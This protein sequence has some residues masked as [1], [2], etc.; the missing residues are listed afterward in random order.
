M[1]KFNNGDKVVP[2]QKTVKGYRDLNGSGAWKRAQILEQEYLFVVDWDEE[3]NCYILHEYKD[4][5]YNGDF[6]N[7]E[8]LYLYGG[9]IPEHIVVKHEDKKNALQYH[10]DEIKKLGF[11]VS[12]SDDTSLILSPLS[13]DLNSTTPVPN[14]GDL[15]DLNEFIDMCESGSLI[16]YDGYG[17][18]IYNEKVVYKGICPSDLNFYEDQLIN[19]QKKLGKIQIIWYNK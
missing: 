8:D 13:I 7:E 10:L 1:R 2:F 11:I 4:R 18:I 5:S 16:D 19:L 15:M 9:E 6:F 14:Y 17:D 3:D 12:T